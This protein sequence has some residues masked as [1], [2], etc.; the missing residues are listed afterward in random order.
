MK[1]ISV[2]K[3]DFP[4]RLFPDKHNPLIFT[5]ILFENI[6]YISVFN[7]IETNKRRRYLTA[8]SESLVN[9][10]LRLKAECCSTYPSKKTTE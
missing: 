1:S 5:V 3:N 7:A 2:I 6:N 4:S 10:V 8:I 9:P